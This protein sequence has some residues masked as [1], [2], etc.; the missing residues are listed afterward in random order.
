MIMVILPNSY[1]SDDSIQYLP[2]SC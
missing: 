1:H 2:H